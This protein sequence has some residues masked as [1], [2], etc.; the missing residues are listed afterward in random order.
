MS[1]VQLTPIDLAIDLKLIDLNNL[2]KNEQRN[3]DVNDNKCKLS[4]Q[5]IWMPTIPQLKGICKWYKLPHP[6]TGSSCKYLEIL[7]KVQFDIV[8]LWH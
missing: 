1:R 6:R 2:N 5:H 7:K 8:I 4:K 3:R